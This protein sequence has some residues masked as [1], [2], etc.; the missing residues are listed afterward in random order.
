MGEPSY[1]IGRPWHKPENGEKIEKQMRSNRER[2]IPAEADDIDLYTKKAE[3]LQAPLDGHR[4][5]SQGGRARPDDGTI[6]EQEIE[7]QDEK[8]ED[9][10]HMACRVE[11]ERRRGGGCLVTVFP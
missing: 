11:N 10:H 3:P 9:G 2:T 8:R 6:Q 7:P 4:C 1:N 5:E